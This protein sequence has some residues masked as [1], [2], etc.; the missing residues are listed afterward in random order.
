MVRGILFKAAVSGRKDP[1]AARRIMTAWY[2]KENLL[3]PFENN[4]TDLS[5]V[6]AGKAAQENTRPIT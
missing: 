2:Y 6:Y 1:K 4:R 3:F 5:M